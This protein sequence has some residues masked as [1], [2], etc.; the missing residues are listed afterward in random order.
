MP[1]FTCYY[2][3]PETEMYYQHERGKKVRQKVRTRTYEGTDSLSFL[4]IK[5]KNNK[6]RT[7]KKRVL[8]EQGE[9]L[10]LY[11]EFIEKHSFYTPTILIPQIENHF[12]R[13]T[14]VDNDLTERITI[15]TFL[16]F[17]N[18]ITDRKLQ[19]YNLGIIEWK[20]D[21]INGKSILSGILRKLHIHESSFSK[22]CIGMAMTSPLLKQGRIKPKI[23]MVE[24]INRGICD[25]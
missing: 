5:N 1:Y 4:E 19:L 9:A 25:L 15:D 22:Y 7:H 20:R 2:D 10:P 13:I 21:G 18:I 3:T 12:F 16:E 14:L 17:N 11:T 24:K 6:G 8:M 23:R